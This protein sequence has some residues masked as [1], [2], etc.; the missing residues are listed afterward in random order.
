MFVLFSFFVTSATANNNENKM[1]ET[2]QGKAYQELH[3]LVSKDNS[4]TAIWVGEDP[5]IIIENPDTPLEFG[6]SELIF[7]FSRDKKKIT[8]KPDGEL[9]YDCWSFNIFDGDGRYVVL[10][11]SQYGPYHVVKIENLRKYLTG[12]TPAFEIVEG[13]DSD[14]NGVIHSC[15][16]WTSNDTFEFAAA[17]CGDERVVRHK[18]GHKT[19]RGLWRSEKSFYS[20]IIILAGLFAIISIVIIVAIKFLKRTKSTEL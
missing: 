18:I 5:R 15:L 13:R 19:T 12:E 1:S 20:W 17:C 4:V 10:L 3:R 11:Q 2:E 7:Q 14:N 8:F 6:V 9:F 16:Y